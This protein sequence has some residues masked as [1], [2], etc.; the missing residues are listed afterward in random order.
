[1]VMAS[2]VV[3]FY[4]WFVAVARSMY[5]DHISVEWSHASEFQIHMLNKAIRA[6]LS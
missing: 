6:D 1:M 3:I 5:P 4:L 2:L